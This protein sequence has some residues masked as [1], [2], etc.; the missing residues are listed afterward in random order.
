MQNNT[1]N[2]EEGVQDVHRALDEQDEHAEDGDDDVE[3]GH[4]VKIAVSVA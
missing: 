4:A 3:L 2:G 1:Q